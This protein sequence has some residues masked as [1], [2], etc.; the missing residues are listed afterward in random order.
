MS[1]GAVP[2]QKFAE[3]FEQ[4][5]GHRTYQFARVDLDIVLNEPAFCQHFGKSAR[6]I[7]DGAPDRATLS[8][9]GEINSKE[10]HCKNV[11]G[12][13]QPDVRRGH[14]FEKRPDHVAIAVIDGKVAAPAR[15]CAAHMVDNRI[16]HI[17]A[18]CAVQAKTKAEVYIF[19]VGEII[20][21]KAADL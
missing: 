12:Q 4:P 17:Q 16:R 2:F 8:A 19:E 18:F 3:G 1:C 15:A 21:V 13:E 6:G 10:H 7:E 9:Q 20:L 14:I 5:Y 11:Q